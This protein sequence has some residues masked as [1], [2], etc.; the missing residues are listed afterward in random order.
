MPECYFVV[1]TS[2]EILDENSIYDDIVTLRIITAEID[3]YE[4]HINFIPI[5]NHAVPDNTG[6]WYYPDKT[7]AKYKLKKLREGY[8]TFTSRNIKVITYE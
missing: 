7:M 1:M 8:L 2:E 5:V 6:W 4:N 3:S